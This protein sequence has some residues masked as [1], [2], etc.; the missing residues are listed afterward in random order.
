MAGRERVGQW[1]FRN[2]SYTPVP[3]ALAVLLLARPTPASM[4]VGGLSV[5]LG[6]LLRLWAVSLTGS[7]TRTTGSV[8]GS[9][10][11]TEGPYAYVR[12]PLYLGNIMIYVGLGIMSMALFPWLTIAGWVWFQVQYSLIIEAEE[13]HLAVVFGEAYDSY[14][15]EVARFVPRLTPYRAAGEAAGRI[16]VRAGLRSERSGLIAVGL[17]TAMLLVIMALHG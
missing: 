3:F 12:N 14:R 4:A 8:G 6:Q 9:R 17:M 7:E 2:R 15:S 1:L 10:L 5:V 13:Q 16:N 11:V